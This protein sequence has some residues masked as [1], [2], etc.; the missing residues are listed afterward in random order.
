MDIPGS[1]SPGQ[2]PRWIKT[3]CGRAKYAEQAGRSGGKAPLRPAC[4]V[5]IAALRDWNQPE[6][7][8]LKS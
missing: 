6:T 2:T 4:F 8:A 7:T 5:L 1:R 3:E